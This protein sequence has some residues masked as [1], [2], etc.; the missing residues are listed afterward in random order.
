MQFY[1]S[2]SCSSMIPISGPGLMD[3]ETEEQ[4][5]ADDAARQTADGH[6]FTAGFGAGSAGLKIADAT[7]YDGEDRRQTK[8]SGRDTNDS[9]DQAGDAESVAGAGV[10]SHGAFDC[11]G[12]SAGSAIVGGDGRG[13]AAARAD[14]QL[15]AFAA[16]ANGGGA[17]TGGGICMDG[18][19]IGFDH[20]FGGRI[21]QPAL[22]V[23]Y[24]DDDRASAGGALTFLRGHQF[25]GFE[26][27]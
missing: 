26:A 3:D 25:V 23:E 13:G 2:L 9:Q 22:P 20:L 27:R 21:N 11:E 19:R 4:T 8:V 1:L 10:R 17:L 24:G 14:D 12:H 6:T 7:E 18:V 5:K 15:L 16:A